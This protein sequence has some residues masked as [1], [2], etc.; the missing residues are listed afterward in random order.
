M[1][2]FSVFVQFTCGLGVF[3]TEENFGFFFSFEIFFFWCLMD[4]FIYFISSEFMDLGY[5][6]RKL[7]NVV[8]WHCVFA[9]VAIFA[10]YLSHVQ[11]T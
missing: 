8:V 1:R 2:V 4:E 11:Q 6:V 9:T 7:E 10:M 3:V 5:A